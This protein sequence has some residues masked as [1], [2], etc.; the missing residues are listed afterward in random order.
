MVGTGESSASDQQ[1]QVSKQTADIRT[2]T[3]PSARNSSFM[4]RPRATSESKDSRESSLHD[5][6]GETSR[7]WE[8]RGMAIGKQCI[9]ILDVKSRNQN[10]L[11]FYWQPLKA[12]AMTA[13]TAQQAR[14]IYLVYVFG[15]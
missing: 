4:V 15:A 9:A 5:N 7:P 6:H 8:A 1:L 2:K 13:V 3:V 10:A 14:F 11:G 12:P